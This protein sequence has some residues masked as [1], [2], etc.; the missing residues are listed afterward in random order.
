MPFSSGSPEHSHC[1]GP[2]Y[3]GQVSDSK[4]QCGPSPNTDSICDFKLSRAVQLS[5]IERPVPP[6][7]TAYFPTTETAVRLRGTRRTLNAR[8]DREAI[9]VTYQWGP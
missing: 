8:G 6:L 7:C 2:K 5:A 9:R 3:K 1:N 4:A